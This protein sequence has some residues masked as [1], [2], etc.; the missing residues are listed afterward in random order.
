MKLKKGQTLTA[1]DP[2]IM[3]DTDDQTLTV[4]KDYT[5]ERIENYD[6]RSYIYIKDDDKDDHGFQLSELF[7]FFELKKD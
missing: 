6:G 5:I 2:C 1:I 7:D 4:G 3:E